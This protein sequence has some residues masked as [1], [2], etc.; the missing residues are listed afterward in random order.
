MPTEKTIAPVKAY[1]SKTLI[2][3][4]PFGQVAPH[5]REWYLERFGTDIHNGIDL[6]LS[7]KRWDSYGSE[8][9]SAI[10]GYVPFV[11]QNAPFGERGN[12]IFV[13]SHDRKV[14]TLH[15]HCAK[16]FVKSGQS[17]TKGQ[18]IGTMGNSGKVRPKPTLS[19]PYAGTHLHFMWQINV[20]GQWVS[21]DPLEHLDL[22]NYIIGEDT[23]IEEDTPPIMWQLQHIQAKI[24][25][26]KRQVDALQK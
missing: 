12:G 20:N 3:T 7:G 24:D 26:I 15:W 11:I 19:H 10:D 17:V 18:V 4:N 6:I 14:Q 8:L 21:V 2:L 1:G 22:G 23:G 5:L 9:V 25:V 13:Q 16:I